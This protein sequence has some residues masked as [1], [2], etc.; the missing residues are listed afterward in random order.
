MALR[1]LAP[2]TWDLI[3]DHLHNDN[4]AL[5]NCS[6]VCR[7]WL[8]SSR[9]HLFGTLYLSFTGSET[10]LSKQ[11]RFVNMA[12]D[13][14]ICALVR[15]LQ[16]RLG[17]S[18]AL[19]AAYPHF[20]ALKKL[21]IT[22]LNGEIGITDIEV[23]TFEH[24]PKLESLDVSLNLTP[25][26]KVLR[27]IASAKNV[28]ELTLSAMHLSDDGGYQD[29]IRQYLPP[30]LHKITVSFNYQLNDSMA[31][32]LSWFGHSGS[33]NDLHMVEF[34]NITRN[35]LLSAIS[36]MLSLLREHLHHI[37]FH[38]DQSMLQGR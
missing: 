16:L 29:A 26:D 36:D 3:I 5:A 20:T 4:R 13:G 7:Q 34:Y 30:Q 10:K 35:I 11:S 24:L 37:S 33:L 23:W 22:A 15:H 28:K 27:L 21:T 25:V 9:Y 17:S 31:K 19:L 18:A 14:G 38:F 2:E 1:T 8:T 12:S 6:L 32:I